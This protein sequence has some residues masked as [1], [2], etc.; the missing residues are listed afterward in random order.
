MGMKIAVMSD[1]H[2]SFNKELFYDIDV[3][4]NFLS[5]LEA[6]KNARPELLIYLG[7]FCMEKPESQVYEYVKS[8]TDKLSVPWFAVPGNHDNA[9]LMSQ[10][11]N[12]PLLHNSSEVCYAIDMENIQLLFCDS[13]KGKLSD[14]QYNWI[15]TN[16]TLE[17]PVFV[18]THYPPTKIGSPYMDEY[19]SFGDEERFREF[20]LEFPSICHIYC[21]HYHYAR[22]LQWEEISIHVTPAT[23]FQINSKSDT[24]NIESQVPGFRIIRIENGYVENEIITVN[25]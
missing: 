3:K 14:D 10:Q 16:C 20:L 17:K 4:K 21:G 19:F 1:L 5:T 15:R 6:V 13:S 18:F 23:C 22:D 7:D 2:L 24:M 25:C 8:H 12:L 9:V 11:F